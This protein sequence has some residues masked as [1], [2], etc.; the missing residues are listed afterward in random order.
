MEAFALLSKQGM[1]TSTYL[2][3]T[4]THYTEDKY[5]LNSYIYKNY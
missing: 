4:Y 2:K 3:N 5:V 1:G